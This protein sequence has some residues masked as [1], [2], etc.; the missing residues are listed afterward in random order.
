V[1]HSPRRIALLVVAVT[2]SA[3]GV[4]AYLRDTRP[5]YAT[6]ALP[7]PGT[8]VDFRLPL[9]GGDTLRARDLHGE[10]TVLAFWSLSCGVSAR[11]LSG[12][13]RLQADY[14]GR[15]RVVVLAD[16]GDTT[17]VR[18]A[19]REAGITVP[20]AL[21]GGRLRQMF[22]RSR[23]APER[24]H[25]RVGWAMPGLLVLDAGGRVAHRHVGLSLDE[26]RSGNVGMHRTRVTLDSL[27]GTAGRTTPAAAPSRAPAVSAR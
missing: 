14:R 24:A 26:Y 6:A 21:A 2:A 27:L 15:A 9:L 12:I 13:E 8:P 18:A 5:L 4:T 25:F 10:P 20:V 23:S 17:A 3:I 22:D 19:M 1:R 7:A 16:D 11:A